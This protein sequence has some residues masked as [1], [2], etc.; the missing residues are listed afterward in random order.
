MTRHLGRLFAAALVAAAAACGEDDAA[1]GEDGA[2]ARRALDAARL[3]VVAAPPGEEDLLRASSGA[4]PPASRVRAFADAGL[5]LEVAATDAGA[6]GSIPALAIGDNAF[7]RLWVVAETADGA[8]D[9]APVENDVAPPAVTI[10]PGP[11]VIEA[12]VATFAFGCDEAS[13]TFAC[14][15]DGGLYAACTSPFTSPAL[16]HGPHQLRVRATDAAGNVSEPALRRFSVDLPGPAVSLDQVPPDPSASPVATFRFS[17]A[18]GATFQCG[19]VDDRW[20]PCTSPYE[21][22]LSDGLGRF[23]VRAVLDG[24]AGAPATYAWRI[25][26]QGP[27]LQVR[28]RPS[29]TSGDPSPLW[30]F[31]C[32]EPC[33]FTCALD[34][35]APAPCTPPVRL[36]D[37]AEGPHVFQIV[38]ADEAGNESVGRFQWEVD[39]TGPGVIF[40]GGPAPAI[41]A[42][43]ASFTFRCDDDRTCALACRLDGAPLAPCASPFAVAALVEGPH[44][45]EVVATDWVGNAGP[46]AG[47]V[48]EVDDTAPTIR[49]DAAPA[50]STEETTATFE[51]ACE[52]EPCTFACAVDLLDAAPCTSPWTVEGLEPGPRSVTLFATDRVGLGAEATFEWTILPPGGAP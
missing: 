39:R 27:E 48:F 52:G 34:E 31:A 42:R 12:R 40:E 44:L 9:P 29:L 21:L 38:A 7:A 20:A 18:P 6:D 36:A 11:E 17:S 19:D 47:Y 4:A 35:A 50:A 1:G 46:A 15:I 32:G 51:F 45:F 43:E 33:T 22:S 16:P 14:G 8:S 30:D 41:R 3:E 10:E 13:C 26:T 23:Q 24:S 37:L 49:I 25:D 28:E 2:P 5:F